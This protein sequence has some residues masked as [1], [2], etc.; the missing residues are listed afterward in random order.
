MFLPF[1]AFAYSQHR[2]RRLRRKAELLNDVESNNN[3]FST[4]ISGPQTQRQSKLGNKMMLEEVYCR[5]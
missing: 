1:G 3:G 4:L 5:D 2:I